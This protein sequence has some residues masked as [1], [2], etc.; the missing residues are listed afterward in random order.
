MGCMQK[1]HAVNIRVCSLCEDLLTEMASSSTL[2]TVQVVVDST[3]APVTP[4][5]DEEGQRHSLVRA[6]DRDVDD[7]VLV[8]VPEQKLR[9]DDQLLRLEPCPRP[10]VSPG[11]LYHRP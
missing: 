1:L 11:P 5:P 10:R 3:S 8:D 7:G 6:V 9:L 2:D 4:D